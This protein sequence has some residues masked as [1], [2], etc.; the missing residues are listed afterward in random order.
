MSHKKYKNI[1]IINSGSS[2]GT[3]L[4]W[5]FAEAGHRLLLHSHDEGAIKLSEDIARKHRVQ[6][7]Y[8][9]A[10][11]SNPEEIRM[12]AAYAEE[13]LGSIDGVVFLLHLEYN[14]PIEEFPFDKWQ[15][16]FQHNVTNTFLV[17]QT[18][19]PM[20]KKQRFGRFI[21]ITS[22]Y[23]IT[24][25]EYKSAY[26]AACHAISGLTKTLALEGG[27][28]GITCNTIAPGKVKTP[29]I[30]E[31]ISD[32]KLAHNISEKQIVKQII[33]KNHPDKAFVEPNSIGVCAL[34]LLSD[35]GK[36]MNGATLPIDGGWTI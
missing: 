13:K 12:M 26:V 35:Y 24:A 19:W 11:L 30:E 23:S 5:I 16:V 27:K 25:S 1:I 29:E 20:M 28:Y 33:L 22:P 3:S 14:A 34:F 4:A 36:S 15:L 9:H 18:L 7:T 21:H 2:L 6:V 8:S 32:H 31:E 17:M 10:D